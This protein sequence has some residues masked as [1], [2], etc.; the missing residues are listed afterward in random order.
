MSEDH[1]AN[2]FD[3]RSGSASM[4]GGMASEIMRSQIHTRE[5]ACFFDHNPSS[6]VGDRKNSFLGSNS[7]I[8]NIFPKSVCDFLR[9][10]HDFRF[11]ATFR[12][13]QCNFVVLTSTDL[14]FSTSPLHIPPLAISSSMIRLRG[15]DVLKMISSIESF[16]MILH[17]S[18]RLA[19]NIF[20][21]MGVSQGFWISKSMVL[22]M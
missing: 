11:P 16:P 2:D 3:W 14:I 21:K 22:Q 18:G 17:C 7:F 20:L 8:L 13:R 10:V 1:F 5:L 12:V 19:L 4:C 15:L 6:I 9:D